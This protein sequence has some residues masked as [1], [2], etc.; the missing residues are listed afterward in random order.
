MDLNTLLAIVTAL[1]IRE[2]GGQIVA[3]W[4]GRRSEQRD[5]FKANI[6]AFRDRAEA[7]EKRAERAERKAD[8]ANRRLDQMWAAIRT[9]PQG[10]TCP[11]LAVGDEEEGESA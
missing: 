2:I 9:C 5:D 7:A 4:T 11:A 1:G 8:R 6:D 10:A 3:A